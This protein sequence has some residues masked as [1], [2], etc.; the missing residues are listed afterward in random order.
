MRKKR[1]WQRSSCP[2]R[3]D[4]AG[5]GVLL[6]E[7]FAGERDREPG[8]LLRSCAGAEGSPRC[9]ALSVGSPRAE[10]GAV[11]GTLLAVRAGG[12]ESGP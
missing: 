2:R 1:G 8:L 7:C 3:A 11:G 6:T 9:P 12:V 4:G 5:G 10:A